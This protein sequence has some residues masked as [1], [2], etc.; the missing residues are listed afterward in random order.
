SYT[1]ATGVVTI[2]F[3]GSTN[4]A[5]AE[6]VLE[7]I[8]YGIDASDQDPSTTARTVTLNTV[9]DN[10]GGADTN[11][12]I[13][14]TATISVIRTN[15]APVVDDQSFL[16]DENSPNGTLVGMV[17]AS[18]PDADDT[19]T[20]SITNGNAAGT[21]AIDSSSGQIL[22]SDSSLL[23]FETNSTFNLTVQVEDGGAL[24]DTATITIDLNDLFEDFVS[25]DPPYPDPI[26]TDDPDDPEDPV[27]DI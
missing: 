9:T 6:L 24:I 10:G 4:A 19:L 18:D 16:L 17:S 26:L 14:E 25:I 21:F 23:D 3:A 11:T 27:D 1:Q 8:T 15:D 5:A 22:V 12:D 2:T 13:S 7:N 20:Y